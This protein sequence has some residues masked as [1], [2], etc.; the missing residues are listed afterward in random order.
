[1]S[2]LAIIGGK[3]PAKPDYLQKVKELSV[4]TP[5]GN[6][7]P[8][9][10]SGYF[11][12]V[13]VLHLS[14]HGKSKKPNT[15]GINHKANLYAL[16]KLDC[17]CIL[18]STTCRSLQEEICPGDIII[19]DQFIDMTAQRISGAYAALNSGEAVY[20]PMADP[21]SADLRDHLVEAAIVK[22]ITVH[23]KGTV[24]SIEGPRYSSRAESNL[25]R[26]W[27]ADVI[28]M[29]TAPEIILAHELA[30]PYAAVAL[31]TGYDTWRVCDDADVAG[32]DTGIISE[33][34]HKIISML[35][36]AMMKAE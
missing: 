11:E 3:G 4:S 12:G 20:R 21:F 16:K 22:G 19:P 5:F 17:S 8:L 15:S 27:G 18:A 36:Y 30:I 13:E 28:N 14:R 24:L 9:I 23:T 32:N 35:T 33:N 10:Y 26:L 2:K 25:Y 34:Y 29:V 1:M 31:C 6:P 7:D